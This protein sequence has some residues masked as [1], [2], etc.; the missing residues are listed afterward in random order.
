MML[1]LLFPQLEAVVRQQSVQLVP[2]NVASF[3]T[4]DRM[5]AAF[6]EQGAKTT[7]FV[8]MEDVAGL[9]PQT[10]RRYDTMVSR[11]RADTT[12]VLLVRDLLTDPVTAAQAV[13]EDGKAWYL[14]VGVAGRWATLPPPHRYKRSA[15]SLQQRS[16]AR[17]PPCM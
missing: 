2:S 3:Q 11:L 1:A 12:H 5:S 13:S 10:R 7:V 8:A 14:P 4:L 6:G 16:E 15:G 9:T 17:R